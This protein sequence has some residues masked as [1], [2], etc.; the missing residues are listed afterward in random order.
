MSIKMP[1]YKDRVKY[2]KYL[3][4]AFKNIYT[5]HNQVDNKNYK[6]F[7]D[8]YRSVSSD[9]IKYFEV[10]ICKANERQNSSCERGMPDLRQSVPEDEGRMSSVIFNNHLIGS[11]WVIKCYLNI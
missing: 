3:M 9:L 7:F 6:F 5:L 8:S 11:I 2:H 4:E 10:H 1:P